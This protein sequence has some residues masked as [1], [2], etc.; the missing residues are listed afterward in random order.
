MKLG[1]QV[2]LMKEP[3]KEWQKFVDKWNKRN[4]KILNKLT[5][6]E[7]LAREEAMDKEKIMEKE[8]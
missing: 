4:E 1:E 5:K 8:E 2:E 7:I 3:E 6:E